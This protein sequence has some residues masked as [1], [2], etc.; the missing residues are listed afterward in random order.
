[1]S[2]ADVQADPDLTV[3]LT[4]L[5][6]ALGGLPPADREEI[7]L[8]TRSHVLEQLGRSPNRRVADVLGELGAPEG[9]ARQFLAEVGAMPGPT[10]E[11]APPT[12]TA[13]GRPGSATLFGLAQLTTRGGRAIPWLLLFGALYVLAGVA[14]LFVIG[15]LL[16]P[17]GTG[18]FVQPPSSPKPHI[19]VVVAESGAPGIDLL[20]RAIIPIGL[21]IVAAIHLAA[22]AM[23]LRVLGHDARPAPGQP[24]TDAPRSS[25]ASSVTLH[26]LARLGAGGW[27]RVPFLLLVLTGYGI[28][29]WGVLLLISEL[30]DPAGTG[31]IVRRIPD[32]RWQVGLMMS[33][34]PGPGEDVLGVWFAPLLLLLIAA[35]HLGI[36]ALLRRE[37]RRDSPRAA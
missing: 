11:P 18:V 16:Y 26:G 37:L 9:Y 4:R 13:G 8:E 22:R 34:T 17:T 33:G 15:D 5:G 31:F 10:L 20:G 30:V 14:L 23:L 27:R 35:I 19:W 3:Y 36:R 21:L 32:D 29:G 24:V 28:A 1:M 7:L 6:A 12:V 25:I 2:R